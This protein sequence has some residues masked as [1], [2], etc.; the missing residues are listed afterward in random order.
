MSDP[1]T[2][3]APAT[4][5]IDLLCLQC[6]EKSN[7]MARSEVAAVRAWW[8]KERQTDESLPVFLQRYGIFHRKAMADLELI[9]KGFASYGV[10]SHLFT[11][12]GFSLL[13]RKAMGIADAHPIAKSALE[14]SSSLKVVDTVCDAPAEPALPPTVMLTTLPIL[15]G[16]GMTVEVMPTADALIGKTIGGCTLV[17][18][19]GR[20]AKCLV[21]EA[22]HAETRRPI[23]VK[24]LA[25]EV[26]R[27]G[28]TWK[29]RFLYEARVA[30]HLD[31]SLL[32]AVESFGEDG[33]YVYCTMPLMHAG[34]TREMLRTQGSFSAYESTRIAVEIARALTV[35]HSRRLIHGN[36]KPSNVFITPSGI[37]KVADASPPARGGVITSP[38][39]VE[40]QGDL[41]MLAATWHWLLSGKPPGQT[42]GELPLPNLCR[43]LLL[44]A[45]GPSHSE[46]FKDAAEFARALVVV[47]EQLRE[48]EKQTKSPGRSAGNV[49]VGQVLGKCLLTEKVGQGSTGSVFRARHLTLNFQVAVKVLHSVG[50]A[51]EFRAEAQALAKLNHP[52]VVRVWDF[53]D[54]VEHPYLVLEFVEGFNLSQ[55]IQQS[56]RL[57]PDRVIRIVAQIADGLSAARRLGIVHRDVKP[58]NI[59]IA[60]DGNAKLADLGL[61]LIANDSTKHKVAG[62]VAYMAPEQAANPT[63]VDHRADIYA[64]GATMYHM[65]TG[66]P[67][68]QGSNAEELAR[69]HASV[70]PISPEMLAPDLN[71]ALAK[72]ILRMLAKSPSERFQSYDELLQALYH[73]WCRTNPSSAISTSGGTTSFGHQFLGQTQK[74]SPSDGQGSEVNLA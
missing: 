64:L 25:P 31:H 59:L 49:K 69:K 32:L 2:R 65:V 15:R 42:P 40:L 73:L 44:R 14:T 43:P 58:G 10:V 60:H 30:A 35:L 4:I 5:A 39:N 13:R 9:A 17:R 51:K 38:R 52:N 29:E 27:G 16:E 37:V 62:T 50:H 71:P 34:S 47:A 8:E 41:R 66:Q 6:L 12:H 45:L 28:V 53:E 55:L 20:G 68:F 54:H 19:L 70:A 74:R 24:L 11:P 21:F 57:H 26:A 46:G 36:L 1:A 22:E 56:G 18:Y 63:A 67:P 48:S 23:A 33:E 61:A 7:L 3:T 72:I